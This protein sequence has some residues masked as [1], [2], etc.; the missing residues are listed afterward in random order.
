[1]GIYRENFRSEGRIETSEALANGAFA[2]FSRVNSLTHRTGNLS[3]QNRDIQDQNRD[4]EDQNRALRTFPSIDSS[5]C[6]DVRY[7]PKTDI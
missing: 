5:E 4:I 3:D 1:V 6:A 7:R 2:A